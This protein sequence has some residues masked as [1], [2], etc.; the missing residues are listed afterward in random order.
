MFNDA[1]VAGTWTDN[2]PVPSNPTEDQ[3]GAT[4][5]RASQHFSAQNDRDAVQFILTTATRTYSLG[6]CAHQSFI[7]RTAASLPSRTSTCL[8]RPAPAAFQAV[9]QA[10]STWPFTS[11]R[12]DRSDFDG[13]GPASTEIGDKCGQNGIPIPPF[14]FVLPPLY[15]N[16][17]QSCVTTHPYYMLQFND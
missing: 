4:A 5:V 17:S 3:I 16:A 1:V 9:C 6:G 12:S 14:A 13:W 10:T 11:C 7:A 15:S 2:T 8:T